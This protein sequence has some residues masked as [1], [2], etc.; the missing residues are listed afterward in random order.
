M[1]TGYRGR[2]ISISVHNEMYSAYGS[3]VSFRAFK[4]V[5]RVFKTYYLRDA[6]LPQGF[7]GVLY[8]CPGVT[9]KRIRRFQAGSNFIENL[10]GCGGGAASFE[11]APFAAPIITLLRLSDKS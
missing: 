1:V 4:W 7:R 2:G 9:L 5:W 3:R 6:L 10:T 8:A 11:A